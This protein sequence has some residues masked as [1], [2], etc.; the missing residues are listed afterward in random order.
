M[1]WFL[2]CVGDL[3]ATNQAQNGNNTCIH[4][5]YIYY[6]HGYCGGFL[7]EVGQLS[8]NEFNCVCTQWLPIT[9]EKGSTCKLI[10]LLSVLAS[11]HSL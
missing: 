9:P 4:L 2:L 11:Q 10:N 3:A 8:A 5:S 6:L 7:K 1:E